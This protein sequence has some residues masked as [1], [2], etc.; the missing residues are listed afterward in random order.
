[1]QSKWTKIL[2]VLAIAA[3]VV[4]FFG[5][6]L[7]RYLT[8]DYLKSRQVALETYHADHQAMTMAIYMVI[9]IVVTALSLP[10]AAVMTLAGGAIFG[11]WIGLLLVSFASTIGATL[12]FLVARF[13]LMDYVKRR[14]GDK[15]KAVYEG[16]EKDGAF[17]LFTLRLVPLFPF[18][19]I[20]LVMGLTPIRTATFYIVSQIGMLA[21]TAVYVNAGTQL[22]QIDS[23]SGILSPGLIFSFALLGIFPWIAKAA[24]AMIRSKKALA[25]YARPKSFDYNL[26][27]IGAGSAGLVTSYIAAAVKAKVALIEKHKMGGDCLNT[28][29]VP[30][31][32]LIR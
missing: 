20:N 27:V 28:G 19:V 8:F 24:V 13:L 29:C 32:A 7:G 14:F 3:L 17:Y 11:F 15:L 16:I 31:K 5:F 22:A 4:V 30:S 6:D 26:V 25:G 2:I 21:G 9:Y 23:I 10:G 18:F 1:M 12:A